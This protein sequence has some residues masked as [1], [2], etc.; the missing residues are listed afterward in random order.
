MFR[1][2]N[3]EVLSSQHSMPSLTARAFLSDRALMTVM[4]GATIKKHSELWAL[5][6]QR[7]PG[8]WRV[9]SMTDMCPALPSGANEENHQKYWQVDAS[10]RP[11]SEEIPLTGQKDCIC[12]VYFHLNCYASLPPHVLW[13]LTWPNKVDNSFSLPGEFSGPQVSAAPSEDYY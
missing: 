13:S 2:Q 8:W 5:F 3:T 6:L 11:F 4:M 9:C 12:L 7:G 10:L 1:I